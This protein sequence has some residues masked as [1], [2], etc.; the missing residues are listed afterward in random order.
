ML[1]KTNSWSRV[2][3][4]ILLEDDPFPWFNGAFLSIAKI[5]KF[6][7]A[8]AAESELAT[9]F[10]TAQEMIPHRQTLITISWPQPK[11]PIQTDSSTAAGVTNKTIVP[12]RDRYAICVAPLPHILISILLLLGCGLQELGWLPYQTPPLHLPQSPW[13]LHA[14]YWSLVGT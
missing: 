8:L 4:D 13:S 7:M 1:N 12:R 2:G 5:I 14:G 3:A 6:V 10:I 11:S 9:I